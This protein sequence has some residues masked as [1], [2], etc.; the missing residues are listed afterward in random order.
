[1]EYKALLIQQIGFLID[2]L[3]TSTQKAIERSKTTSSMTKACEI[4]SYALINAI[5]T[6][7]FAI[8][9]LKDDKMLTIWQNPTK[10]AKN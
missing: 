8:D 5:Q 7:G 6:I 2:E 10:A 3:H 4:E 9:T 1:M